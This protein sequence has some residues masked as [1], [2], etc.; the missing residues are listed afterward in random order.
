MKKKNVMN[1]LSTNFCKSALSLSLKS[2][3]SDIEGCTFLLYEQKQPE[4]LKKTDIQ[5]LYQA[6]KES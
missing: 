5:K 1:N 3:G 6:V 2:L 4:G